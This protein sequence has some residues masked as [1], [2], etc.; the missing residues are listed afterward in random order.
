[1]REL[2]IELATAREAR[3]DVP[4]GRNSPTGKKRTYAAMRS[5]F[6]NREIIDAA[7]KAK[8]ITASGNLSSRYR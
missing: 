7:V 4:T 5:S 8:I 3:K 2:G 1:M 6:S